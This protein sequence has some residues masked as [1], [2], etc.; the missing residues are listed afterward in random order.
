[1]MRLFLLSMERDDAAV[2]TADCRRVLAALLLLLMCCMC[3]SLT[4]YT[5]QGWY[6]SILDR[7]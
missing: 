3:V 6:A 5:R 2:D 1:M 4:G 7:W